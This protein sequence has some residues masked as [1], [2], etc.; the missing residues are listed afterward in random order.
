MARF[1][2]KGSDYLCVYI[3]NKV[4]YHARDYPIAERVDERKLRALDCDR[5]VFDRDAIGADIAAQIASCRPAGSIG[6]V[7]A[8]GCWIVMLIEGASTMITGA[9]LWIAAA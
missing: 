7:R 4:T 6:A 9:A 1:D 8:G 3:K 2:F 5:R